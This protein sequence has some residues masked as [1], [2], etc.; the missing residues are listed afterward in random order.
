M[1]REMRR[2]RSCDKCKSV[3]EYAEQDIRRSCSL[4]HGFKSTKEWLI[5]PYCGNRVFYGYWGCMK[6]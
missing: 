3:F 1:I 4:N 2:Q 6:K 5:C